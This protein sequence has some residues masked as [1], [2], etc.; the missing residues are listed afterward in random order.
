MDASEAARLLAKLPRTRRREMEMRCIVC[1]APFTARRVTAAYCSRS[2]E[3]RA[4]RARRG[5]EGS[6]GA[7]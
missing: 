7:G 1:G 5:A 4:Y 6:P 3:A 2:C